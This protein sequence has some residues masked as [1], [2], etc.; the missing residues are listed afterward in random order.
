M[1]PNM[2]GAYGPWAASLVSDGPGRLSFRNDAFHDVDAWRKQARAGLLE[3][4]AQPETG[5]VPQ[6]EVHHQFEYDGL[7]IEDLQWRLPY[8]P[9][10]EA[11][12][13]KPAGAEGR[14][15]AALARHPPR[16]TH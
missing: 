8:G 4:L 12:F 1:E 11:V 16:R 9:P 7:A 14:L 2:L 5:G 3:C 6:A 10:T 15:P 13:L